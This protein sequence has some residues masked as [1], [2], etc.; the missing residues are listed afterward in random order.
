MPEV[1]ISYRQTNDAQRVR[2]RE[3]AERL[4]GCGIGVVL[5]QFY[6][7]AHPAGPPEGWPKWS[8]DQA[9]SAKQVIVI[10]SEAWFQCFDGTQP[11]GTGLG[12][13]CEAH[14]LRQRNYEAA[15]VN[16]HIRVVVFDAADAARISFHLKC[17]HYFH[18]DADFAGIV[19]WLGGRVP[20]TPAPVLR[21]DIPHNLPALQPFFGREAELAKI[22]EALEAESRTWGV[23]IDAPGGMG[24]TSLA[25]RAAYAADPAVF[26]K[27]VFV[28][29]KSRELDDDGVRDLSGFMLSG[30]VELFSELAR[31][32]GH[33]DVLKAAE[34]LRPR[35][36]L[37]ALAGTQT[38]LILDN[39]ESLLKKERDTVFTFVKR[40]PPGCKAILTARGRIGSGAEELI[41]EKL[42]EAAALATLAELATHNRLL[43]QTSEAERLVLYRETGGKP[44]L[45]RWTA[46]QIG[47][48]HCVTFADAIAHLRSC[49]AGNDPLEFIFGD[50][51]QDF[52]AEET[53]ALC[54]LTYFTQP[55]QVV[56]IAAVA[57]IEAVPGVQGAPPESAAETPDTATLADMERALRS[58]VNRSLVVPSDEFQRFILVPLV[59][60]FLRKAKP[61]SVAETGKRLE[62]RA[63]ALILENGYDEHER[64]P[65]L[66][67]AWPSV[68]PAMPRFVAGANARLQEVCDA[69]RGFLEFTGRWDEWLAL[70]QQAETKAVTAGD[71][72]NAGWRAYQAGWV[73]CLRGQAEAVLDCA[74]RAA[75]HWALAFP[76]GGGGQAGRRERAI[77]I[78]LRGHGH[79]LQRD[80]P[81]AIAAF[82]ESVD[83]HRSLSAESGDVAI[84]LNDLAV[85]ERRSGDFAAAERDYREALRVARAVGH[86]ESV[87]FITGNLAALALERKDWPGAEALA[88]EAL[89]LSEKVGRLEMIATD[90]HRIACALVR[91]GRGAAGLPHARRAVEIYTRL[92]SPDLAQAQKILRECEEAGGNAE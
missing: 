79:R 88:R 56:H 52:S 89:L 84:G 9:I 85:A 4:R 21:T 90:H 48:G 34:E 10:G 31:L 6:L 71:H 16:E 2:V 64:F 30:L 82:R 63:Y 37:D 50:L 42:D 80:Y 70:E 40:L 59:A 12:A 47:R 76:P 67:A 1:F 19:R 11:P 57:G 58:L 86:D 45:L 55:A 87:A 62:Q 66:D 39:L 35:L 69:L 5:D 78:R 8:S 53:R 46:G 92:G 15:G 22:A 18:A 27:I 29:L 24:K 61:E 60:D 74:G 36:L 43:A 73:H 81:A 25:V 38:L 3:F 33:A 41:L 65:V 72:E 26:H 14:E 28:T 20:A 51:V 32:L 49:P 44:L 91:Q 68:A 13:A 83:L 77:A 54:A 23:L 17:Y 7:D 75:A